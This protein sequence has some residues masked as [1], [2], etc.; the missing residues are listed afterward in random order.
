MTVHANTLEES[1]TDGTVEGEGSAT[2]GWGP[3]K[4]KIRI[5]ASA[6]TH[7]SKK[8]ESDY[9]STTDAELSMKR[10]PMPETLAKIMDSLGEMTTTAMAINQEIVSREAAKATDEARTTPGL[11]ETAETAGN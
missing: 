6:S 1:A 9:T 10:Q 2:V 5:K 8:R 11:I 3:I 7:S 4:A